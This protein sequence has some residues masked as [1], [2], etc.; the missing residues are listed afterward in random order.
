M[1]KFIIRYGLGDLDSAEVIEANSLDA[2]G[3]IAE[4]AAREE[5]ESYMS[6]D[7]EV[8]TPE[9]AASYGLDDEEETSND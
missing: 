7:A 8:Y 1:P 4:N 6:W 3:E 9:A 5:A 2:A